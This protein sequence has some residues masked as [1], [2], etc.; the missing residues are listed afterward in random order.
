[1]EPALSGDGREMSCSGG[2]GV[3]IAMMVCSL[4]LASDGMRVSNG[5]GLQTVR[6]RIVRVALSRPC[7]WGHP[8][9]LG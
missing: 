1:M 4:R 2:R 3:A 5:H 9:G 6:G 7:G 8:H